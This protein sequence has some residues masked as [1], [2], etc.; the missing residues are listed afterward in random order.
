MVD[1]ALN[2]PLTRQDLLRARLQAGDPLIAVDLAREFGL[3][4]DTIRRDLLALEELGILQR[5]RGGAV[6][7]RSH[8]TTYK[9]RREEPQTDCDALVKAAVPL[10]KEGMTIMVDGG[11]TLT[12]LARH[13]APL[14]NLLVVTPSPTV[15]AIMLEKDI[16]TYLIGG[17]ISPWGGVATGAEAEGAIR[18]LAADLAFV[19]ICGLDVDFG[20]SADDASEAGV[21]RAMASSASRTI[22]ILAHSKLGQR[23]RHRVLPIDQLGTIITDASCDSMQPFL[24]A[25]AEIIHV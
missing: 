3:S 15:A 4:L 6:P 17:Q 18:N 10:I 1:L 5:V 24:S 22:L 2:N 23:A 7:V 8:S 13:I 21:M 9:E 25:G 19:G 20:L 11:T 12:H 16:A 14:R